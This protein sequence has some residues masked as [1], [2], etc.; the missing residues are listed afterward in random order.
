METKKGLYSTLGLATVGSPHHPLDPKGPGEG[1]QNH[2]AEWTHSDSQKDVA[3]VL[4]GRE[5]LK[6]ST[7]TRPFFLLP[8]NLVLPSAYPSQK[9]G[10]MGSTN[11]T[12]AGQPSRA[13][14][15]EW[16]QKDKWNMPSRGEKSLTSLRSNVLTDS[17]LSFF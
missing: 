2:W 10:L 11:Q 9:V 3:N 6:D 12:H 15:R 7:P 4:T 5:G 17:C 1:S 16:R 13:R 8:L 14:K